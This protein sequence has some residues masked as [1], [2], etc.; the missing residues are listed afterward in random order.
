MTIEQEQVKEG[1]KPDAPVQESPEFKAALSTA[2]SKDQKRL[3]EANKGLKTAQK[4]IIELTRQVAALGREAEVALLAGDDGE[5]KDVARKIL[6]A[7]A[8]VDEARSALKQERGEITVLQREYTIQSLAKEYGVPV[9]ELEDLETVPEMRLAAVT[10]QNEQLRKG[11]T[12]PK[13]EE[14]LESKSID[15]SQGRVGGKSIPHPISDP[16]GYKKYLAEV[17][18]SPEYRAGIR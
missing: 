10:F 5:G 4:E 2:T 18:A 8:E 9:S 12:D 1:V 7:R 16:E 14:E 15:R 3:A 17:R 11:A 13:D 6:E